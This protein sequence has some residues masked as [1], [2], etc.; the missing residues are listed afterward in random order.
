M[1]AATARGCLNAGEIEQ[2][3]RAEPGQLS[4]ELVGHLASCSACQQRL[5]ALD[6]PE[7]AKR[8]KRGADTSP[9]QR[10]LR[11]L[12]VLAVIIAALLTMLRLAR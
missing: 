6:V 3:L 2:V 1:Q 7:P 4:P 5:L 8:G 9:G 12:V 11:V 10:L